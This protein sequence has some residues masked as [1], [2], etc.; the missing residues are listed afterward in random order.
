MLIIG[1]IVVERRAAEPV[2]PLALFRNKVFA[3]ASAIGFIVGFALFGV[4]TF[5]SSFLQVVNGASPTLS[6]LRLLPLMVGLLTTSITSGQLITRWGRYKIFPIIGT[7][8]MTLGLFLLSYMNEQTSVVVSS[9]Y[10]LVLGLGLG[11]VMQVLVIAV[12]NAVD[13]RNLG[14]ATSGATFFRSIGGSFGMEV[15]GTIFSNLLASK[16]AVLAS[17]FPPGFNASN[18]ENTT[19]IQHLPSNIRVEFIHAYAQS[20]QT[21]FLIAHTQCFLAF[22]LTLLLPKKYIQDNGSGK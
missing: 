15:F 3:V 22:I 4:T 13:Y 11:L 5:L 1:F 2:L 21:V 19:A 14:A 16:I 6:G 20:L 9:L 7:A 12:Q 17:S 8:L 10:M 18:A